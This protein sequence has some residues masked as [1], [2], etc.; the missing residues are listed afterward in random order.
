[1]IA[2]SYCVVGRD[3]K[4]EFAI[5]VRETF[6]VAEVIRLQCFVFG[7]VLPDGYLGSGNGRRRR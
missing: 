4:F 7:I 6:V 3:S 5:A 2:R 1:L